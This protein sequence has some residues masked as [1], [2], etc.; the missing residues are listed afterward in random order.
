MFLE[1]SITINNDLISNVANESE[2]NKED[3]DVVIEEKQCDDNDDMVCDE[4]KIND[5][6]Y[7]SSDAATVG[8]IDKEANNSQRT[9]ETRISSNKKKLKSHQRKRSKSMNH[10]ASNF[11][12]G[13]SSSDEPCPN[14]KPTYVNQLRVVAEDHSKKHSSKYMIAPSSNTKKFRVRLTPEEVS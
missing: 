2:K 4:F 1:N 14:E 3:V 8:E 5:S 11:A 7:S 12:L 6:M 13:G 9:G 10:I